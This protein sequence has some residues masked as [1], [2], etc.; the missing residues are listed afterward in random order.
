VKPVE[1]MLTTIDEDFKRQMSPLMRQL[2]GFEYPYP[3]LFDKSEAK[4]AE[5]RVKKAG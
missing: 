3:Q 5:G 2:L 1:D 4:N